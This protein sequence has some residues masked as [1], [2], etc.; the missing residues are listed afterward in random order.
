MKNEDSIIWK[1]T[2][3]LWVTQKPLFKKGRKNEITNYRPISLLPSLS[4]IIEKI[5]YK[6]LISC[7]NEN[8]ILANEQFGFKKNATKNMATYTSLNN[9]QLALDKKWLVGGIFCDLQKASDCVSH[10]ILLEKM[11]YYGITGTA[12]KLMQSYLDNRYQRTK[13]KDKSLNTTFSSWELVKNGV[14]QGSVLGPLM[15]LIYINDLPKTINKIATSVIFADDTGIIITNNNKIDFTNALQQ[16]I[17]EMSSWF[18]SN[19]LTLNYDK[20]HFL[21]F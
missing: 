2:D 13:I 14:P 3:C 8:N 6:R 16:T 21:Q 7:L 10:N 9:I 19:L 18:R 15:F 1:H 5:I 11:E 12:H 17:I 4:K 20:T